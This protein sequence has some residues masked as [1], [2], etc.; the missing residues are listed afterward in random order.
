[1]KIV[2]ITGSIGCGKTYIA[3]IIHRLGYTVYNID[4][5][6]KYLYYKKDFLN[7]IKRKF[8]DTFVDGVFN[9]RLLRNKV[10]NDN[11][12]LKE[13]EALIHPFLKQKLLKTIKH[14]SRKDFIIFLDVALLYEM[15]WD[16]Y[17]D[18]VIL[19]DVDKNIQKQRVMKRDNITAEDFEKIVSLQMD[20]E[21]KKF[22]A[23]IIVNTAQS[24]GMIKLELIDFIEDIK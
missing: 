17:C 6:V 10:F 14:N 2:A 13:L 12:K 5:W 3:D 21:D 4:K 11:K 20:N 8:P 7:V 24:E 9:K 19:A 15:H 1:M 18:Y 23:D 16:K 22:F